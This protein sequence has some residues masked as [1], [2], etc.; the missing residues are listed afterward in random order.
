MTWD[1]SPLLRT[2]P[3]DPCFWLLPTHLG[4]HRVLVTVPEGHAMVRNN[5]VRSDMQFL[6]ELAEAL[7]AA[8]LVRVYMN[9]LYARGQKTWAALTNEAAVA[10][11]MQSRVLFVVTANPNPPSEWTIWTRNGCESA[12]D[13]VRAACGGDDVRS[14]LRSPPEGLCRLMCQS[15]DWESVTSAAGILQH[16]YH[17]STRYPDPEWMP[18]YPVVVLKEG[19]EDYTHLRALFSGF[20]LPYPAH[21]AAYTFLLGAFHVAS[22]TQ[23]RPILVIDSW[24]RGRGKTELS[25]AIKYLLDKKEGVKSGRKGRDHATDESIASLREDRVEVLDNIDREV[26][27][28]HSVAVTA[29]TSVLQARGKFEAC[30]AEFPGKLFL[31]NCVIGAASFHRDLL[32]RILRVEIPGKS[33]ALAVVPIQYA[34]QHRSEIIYEIM[35]AH[36][37]SKRLQVRDSRMSSFLSE[38]L[39]AYCQVFGVP[40]EKA[41]TALRYA[42][43]SG[44]VYNKRALGSLMKLYPESLDD[45]YFPAGGISEE[46]LRTGNFEIPLT[47]DDVGA[48]AFGRTV[49]Q[50]GPKY[51]WK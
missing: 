48:C 42:L 10:K 15:G 28:L 3:G 13:F 45:P 21:C 22:L 43:T 11:W 17:K 4:P 12:H 7:S 2:Y 40:E 39:S 19:P 20:E 46:L 5:V 44:K 31:M 36:A 26:D 9:K 33:K 35:H 24:E 49:V 29:T 47:A 30:S 8:G 25:S 6:L 27:Y 16:P 41:K 18:A 50:E 34:K 32:A 1:Q 23:P 37:H 38:G 14:V 51:V